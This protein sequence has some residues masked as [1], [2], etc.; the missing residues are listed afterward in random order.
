MELPVSYGPGGLRDVVA[1]T[2][3]ALRVIDLTAFIGRYVELKSD[4]A[5]YFSQVPQAAQYGGTFTFST[6]RVAAVAASA[7][8]S[9]GAIVPARLAADTG[10]QFFV[11][12]LWT[13][14]AVQAQST[15]TAWVEVK[16]LS[17]K[18]TP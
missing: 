16:A 13:G 12:G 3:G 2:S 14:V 6:S 8:P 7:E 17:M 4:V 5:I 10:V 1:I 9:S 15:S 18:I 11:T